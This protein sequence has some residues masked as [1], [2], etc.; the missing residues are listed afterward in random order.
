MHIKCLLFLLCGLHLDAIRLQSLLKLGGEM[1]VYIRS[2]LWV[3]RKEVLAISREVSL[4]LPFC[5]PQFCHGSME[6]LE[7]WN[8]KCLFKGLG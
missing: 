2:F 6:N 4:L 5:I 7:H 3:C 8:E 1:Q